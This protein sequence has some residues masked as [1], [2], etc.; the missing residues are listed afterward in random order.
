V[1]AT[2]EETLRSAGLSG[3]KTASILDLAAKVESGVVPLDGIARLSDEE[4]IE[5]LTIVRGIGRWTAEM[6]LMFQLG[7]RDVWPVD[8]YGVRAGYAVAYG[9]GDPPPPKVLAGLGDAFRPY[10]SIAAWYLWRAIELSRE[11]QRDERLKS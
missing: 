8:D 11:A 5:R 9:L 3:A 7:R 1:L 2:P 10:R 6:F 4:I